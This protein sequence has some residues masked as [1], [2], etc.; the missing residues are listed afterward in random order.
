MNL[1]SKFDEMKKKDILAQSVDA[2][3]FSKTIVKL[4]AKINNSKKEEVKIQ[5]KEET[6]VKQNIATSKNETKV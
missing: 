3:V 5:K 6:K 1:T 2:K 4:D